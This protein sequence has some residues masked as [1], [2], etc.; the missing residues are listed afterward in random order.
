MRY[1][2]PDAAQQN[3]V[4]ARTLFGEAGRLLPEGLDQCD[5]LVGI[6]NVTG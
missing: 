3:L 4:Q 6:H 1:F 2:G 5:Q